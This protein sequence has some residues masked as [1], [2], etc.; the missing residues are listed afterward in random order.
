MSGRTAK[1]RKKPKFRRNGNENRLGM[2]A[3]MIA[4]VIMTLVVGV[5]SISLKQKEEKY[6]AREEE[7]LELIADEEART[8]ELE[9]LATY[10]KTK[11]YAEEVAKEKLGLVYENEIIFQEVD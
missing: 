6:A 9:E 3:A 4:I 7:L 1:R 8:Q 11:K 5:N 2:T 10:T